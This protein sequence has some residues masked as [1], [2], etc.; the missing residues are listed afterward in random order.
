[1]KKFFLYVI[2]SVIVLATIVSLRFSVI[3]NK[4]CVSNLML[5]NIEALASGEAPKGEV[6]I[7]K[8]GS[9]VSYGAYALHCGNCDTQMI[10]ET[11]DGR[12]RK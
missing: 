6:H 9:I 3:E 11:G 2:V 5:N 1:M 7:C 8:V 12:C 10:M 4:N